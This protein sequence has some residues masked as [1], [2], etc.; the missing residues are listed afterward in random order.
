MHEPFLEFEVRPSRVVRN[1]DLCEQRFLI[2]PATFQYRKGEY[3]LPKMK[4]RHFYARQVPIT[5]IPSISIKRFVVYCVSSVS[6]SAICSNPIVLYIFY[7]FSKSCWSNIIGRSGFK[8]ERQNIVRSFFKS[9]SLYH[10]ATTLDTAEFYLTT[11]SVQSS[12][13]CGSVHFMSWKK[14]KNLRPT[15]VHLLLCEVWFALHQL[16]QA[17]LLC[18]IW[19]I[20]SMGLIVPNTFE[21]WATETSFVFSFNKVSKTSNFNSPFSL[22]GITRSFIFLRSHS[23]CQG[24]TLE[25]CS[26]TETMI[27]LSSL[28]N[29]SP[30][31]NAIKLM[32]SVVPRVKIISSEEFALIN[33]QQLFVILR[34][35]RSFLT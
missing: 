4:L 10:F 35:L 34:A 7:C 19:I 13:S 25:W 32:A 31:E 12:N 3:C 9:Y 2:Y 17:P 15:L 29:A 16:L 28:Q 11:L 1:D 5:R 8:F 24:T 20:F 22:M 27:S 18:A 30:N 23:I 6:Y 26:R 33:S 14:R 21:T